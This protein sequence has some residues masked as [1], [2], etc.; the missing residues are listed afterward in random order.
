MCCVTQDSTHSG[1]APSIVALN[2]VDQ[3][4]NDPIMSKLGTAELQ[5]N[6][7]AGPTVF[8]AATTANN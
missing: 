4:N 3:F 1:I 5:I 8:A 2:W 6:T 7:I